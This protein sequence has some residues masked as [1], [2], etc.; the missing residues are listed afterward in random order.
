M[1]TIQKSTKDE[2]VCVCVCVCVYTEQ[3]G[4]S[5][6]IYVPDN[7]SIYCKCLPMSLIFSL[8]GLFNNYFTSP[9]LFKLIVH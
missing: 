5:C 1:K 7:F 8:N 9:L 3:L 4:Q 2:D 6:I